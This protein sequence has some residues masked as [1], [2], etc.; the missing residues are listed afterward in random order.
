M[1]FKEKIV[2]FFAVFFIALTFFLQFSFGKVDEEKVFTLLKPF[3]VGSKIKNGWVISKMKVIGNVELNLILIKRL[4]LK[5]LVVSI[6]KKTNEMPSYAKLKNYDVLFEAKGKTGETSP[7][8][9]RVMM[10]IVNLIKKNDIYN[11]SLL[12][13]FSYDK[14]ATNRKTFKFGEIIKKKQ[15]K[16]LLYAFLIIIVILIVFCL[17]YFP[18]PRKIILKIISNLP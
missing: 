3:K 15:V 12:E 10:F 18:L 14:L 4:P 9:D 17:F 7:D 1:N 5:K 8:I 2:V 16:V 6:R 13:D 11:E